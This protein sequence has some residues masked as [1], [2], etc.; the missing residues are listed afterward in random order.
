MKSINTITLSD[1]M[2]EPYKIGIL[3]NDQFG[4]DLCLFSES[5]ENYIYEKGIH[6]VAMESFYKFC[7]EIIEK[8][9]HRLNF[10]KMMEEKNGKI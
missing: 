5:R 8:Y 1:L 2:A 7:K 3:K 4:Y 10:D 9:D 6:P